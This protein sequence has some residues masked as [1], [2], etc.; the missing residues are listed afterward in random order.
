M[1]KL[2][3]LVIL[4]LILTQVIIAER[5]WTALPVPLSN[6]AVAA[7]K[8]NKKLVVFSFM[9]IGPEK[10]WSAISNRAFGLDT[11]NGKWSEIRPVPGPAG[12]LGSVAVTVKDVIYLLGGYTVDGRGD[13]TTVSSVELLVPSRGIWYRAAD[14]PVPL[15]DS[16]AAVYRDRFVYLISGWSQDKP[17]PNVQVY[18]VQKDKWEQAT[19]V[20]GT[21]VFGH[22]GGLVNDSIVYC[23][24]AYKNPAGNAPQYVASNDCW[25]GKIDHH[26][27]TKIQWN[28][29]PDHPGNARY[30]IAAAGSDHDQRIYFTGGTDN[31]Y[32]FNGIGYNGRPSEPSAMTFA[33]NLRTNKWEVIN[34]KT[35]NPTLDNRSLV[36]TSQGLL[37]VGGME[38][39]QKVTSKLNLIPRK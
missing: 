20:P 27:I 25:M 26:D 7:A 4:L 10:T 12:R 39:G 14:M 15:D 38:V 6:N 8:V 1:K 30:R 33:F 29:L 37:T 23:D 11:E 16:V 32:N 13:E 35:P 3:L 19:P 21:P 5:K 36:V 24:G 2:C 34:D 28:K 17:V 18:D 31:P 22:A 9:G